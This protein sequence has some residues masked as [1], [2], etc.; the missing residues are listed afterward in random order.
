MERMN[1]ME[2]MGEQDCIKMALIKIRPCN[3]PRIHA[4]SPSGRDSISIT[5]DR[6]D[7]ISALRQLRCQLTRSTTHLQ[8]PPTI[9]RKESLNKIVSVARFELHL[10]AF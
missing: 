3:N 2:R 8:N 9:V 6:D 1:V 7:R 5:V 10:C 4:Q